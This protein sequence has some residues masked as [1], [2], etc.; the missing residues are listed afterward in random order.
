MIQAQ[1]YTPH[2]NKDAALYVLQKRVEKLGEL[3]SMT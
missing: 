1:H 2:N 3:G